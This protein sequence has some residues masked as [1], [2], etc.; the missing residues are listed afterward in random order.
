V[1]F[2]TFIL[3]GIKLPWDLEFYFSMLE[4]K[5]EEKGGQYCLSKTIAGNY[6]QRECT[7]QK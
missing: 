5:R 6:L 7:L 2:H 1:K 4:Q 3:A